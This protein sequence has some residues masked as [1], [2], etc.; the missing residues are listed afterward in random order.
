MLAKGLVQH[1][2]SKRNSRFHIQG[3][4]QRRDS[5]QRE[6]LQGLVEILDLGEVEDRLSRVH[7]KIIP[8]AQSLK[9]LRQMS[10]LQ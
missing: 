3:R 9:S 8:T 4:C 2:D 7:D 1:R 5:R 10:I 6:H